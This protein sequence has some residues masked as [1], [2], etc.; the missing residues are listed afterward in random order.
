[1]PLNM[2]ADKCETYIQTTETSTAS[3]EAKVPFMNVNFDLT[4]SFA[5]RCEEPSELRDR[6]P[7]PRRRRASSTPEGQ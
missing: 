4:G 1:M 7:A 5:A 3:L 2:T 6:H